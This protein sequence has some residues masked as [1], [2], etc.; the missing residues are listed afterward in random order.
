MNCMWYQDLFPLG[1]E[2]DTLITDLKNMT[3][4]HKSKYKE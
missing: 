2:E 3:K 1:Q 4:N